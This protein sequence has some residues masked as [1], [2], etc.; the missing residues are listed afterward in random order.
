MNKLSKLSKKSRSK[1]TRKSIR[2][3]RRSK[4]RKS[5]RS[6]RRKSR[7]TRTRRLR[8]KRSKGRRIKSRRSR[9]MKSRRS[10]RSRNKRSKGIRIKSRRSRIMK[11]RRSRRSKRKSRSK[12]TRRSKKI[13]SKRS[14]KSIIKSLLKHKDN[15]LHTSLSLSSS[16][17][18][19][20]Y[21]N[22]YLNTLDRVSI[23]N[24]LKNILKNV[25]KIYGKQCIH[26][27]KAELLEKIQINKLLGTGTFGNVYSACAPKPCGDN[28]Y[29]FAVKLSSFINKRHYNNPFNPEEQSW[30][31]FFILKDY[32]NPLVE[33]GICPNLPL[34]KK[35]I[36]VIHVNL[37]IIV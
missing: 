25:T 4:I 20:D 32:I 18:K 33:R 36:Y 9:I 6:R 37:Q 21:D 13:R 30:H 34:Y 7:K 26:G 16:V 1:R 22:I 10:R 15:T 12:R 19:L 17:D 24:K 31:E 29:K 23:I 8:N 3:S 11:S 28:S 27:D 5:K 35:V 2:K 14:K